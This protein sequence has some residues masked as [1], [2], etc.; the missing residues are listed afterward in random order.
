MEENDI[1]D[2]VNQIYELAKQ[3]GIK[4]IYS[5]IVPRKDENGE[6]HFKAQRINAMLGSKFA[7]KEGILLSCN[8]N[9]YVNGVIDESLYEDDVHLNKKGQA[10]LHRIQDTQFVER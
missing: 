4:V 1:V 7:A 9:F 10:S 8:L 3:R 6:S 2:K 5:T